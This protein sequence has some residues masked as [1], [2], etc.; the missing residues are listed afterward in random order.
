MTIEDTT[1]AFR[2][3]SE[4]P[5]APAW[6]DVT[7]GL[8]KGMAIKGAA[9]LESVRLARPRMSLRLPKGIAA[10]AES[11]LGEGLHRGWRGASSH[12]DASNASL[13]ACIREETEAH[14][15][16]NVTRTAAYMAMYKAYPELHWA[17]L[18]HVVSRNGGW[19]MTDLQ[20][21]WLPKLLTHRDRATL[22]GMLESCN[23]LIFRDAYPQL[24][25][26]G[27]SRRTGRSRFSLLPAFGVSAFMR[28]FWERFWI[29]RDAAA[30]TVAL[31]VN[32]QQVIERRVVQDPAYKDTVLGSTAFKGMRPLQLQQVIVPLGDVRVAET[33]LRNSIAR[34]AG[35]VGSEEERA[36]TVLAGRV[37][38]SFT[39]VDERIAFGKSLYAMLFAYPKVLGGALAYAETVSHTGSRADYW[40][41]RFTAQNDPVGLAGESGGETGRAWYSPKLEDAWP[42]RPLGS[43]CDGDWLVDLH[44]LKHFRSL[45]API[46]FVM[47][48]EHAFGQRKLQAASLALES[49]KQRASRSPT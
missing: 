11:E 42:D 28:P 32:E 29:E 10:W 39:N 8:V 16:N 41:E 13:V 7:G 34:H 23:A 26:Y 6:T 3:K 44:V 33:G 19:N 18:A 37:L 2:K 25:L 17:L 48:H 36:D 31:I 46:V 1:G 38:E 30:L 12:L 21:A 15:R 9:L 4:Q 45:R 5:T 27:E 35:E 22:F 43:V 20:G 49:L 14:N 24:R 47:T 40:P